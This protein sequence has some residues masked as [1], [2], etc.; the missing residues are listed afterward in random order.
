MI[1]RNKAYRDML[2]EIN[3]L[4]AQNIRIE[5]LADDD[6]RLLK[7]QQLASKSGSD[8]SFRQRTRKYDKRPRKKLTSSDYQMADDIVKGLTM[9]EIRRKY[10]CSFTK[11]YRICH[12]L[13]IAN[14]PLFKYRVTN[15]DNGIFF[16]SITQIRDVLG[17]K[18]NVNFSKD[19]SVPKM[20]KSL[21]KHNI[22]LEVGSWH[23]YDL[24]DGES[25]APLNET[26]ILTKNGIE[27][28][29]I[30]SNMGE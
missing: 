24:N 23:W 17:K 8:E 7:I 30:K 21:A 14:R 19:N 15:R 29:G 27:S 11:I 13:N 6:P 22:K 2:S 5:K 16:V 20:K 3:L 4:D 1:P 12:R 9:H 18:L 25:Y 26:K 28:Y 10:Q